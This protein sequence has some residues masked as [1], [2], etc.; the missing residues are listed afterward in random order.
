MVL[1]QWSLGCEQAP[2]AAFL[3]CFICVPACQPPGE[4]ALLFTIV[5]VLEE[6]PT[7]NAGV[8]E[9]WQTWY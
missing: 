7:G 4:R 5:L 9:W 8:L 2:S 1:L 6:I 3:Q